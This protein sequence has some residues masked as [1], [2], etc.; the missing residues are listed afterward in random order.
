MRKLRKH[1]GSTG[2]LPSAGEWRYRKWFD[3]RIVIDAAAKNF[4]YL[5]AKP[6]EDLPVQRWP[7]RRTRLDFPKPV[8]L[9]LLIRSC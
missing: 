1:L 9:D 4:D 5:A 3:V 7:R 8:G 6:S 2:N